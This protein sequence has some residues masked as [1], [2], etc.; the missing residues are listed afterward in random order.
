MTGTEF[1]LQDAVRYASAFTDATG[2]GCTI[3]DS[4]GWIRHPAP[5]EH[6]CRLCRSV[7]GTGIDIRTSSQSHWRRVE[8]AVRFGG[9]YI[10]LCD[11][12]FTHWTSPIV[13]EARVVGALV[14]G[15][16]LTIDDEG[17]FEN[18]LLPSG[19]GDEQRERLR[20]LFGKVPR[21][22][23]ARVTAL[24]RLV[25]ALARTISDATGRALDEAESE[26]ERQS[27][28][29]E[30]IHDLKMQ[31]RDVGLDPEIPTYPLDTERSLLDQIRMGDISRAQETLNELLGH[32]FFASGSEID[33]IRRRTRELVVLL[34]RAV[35]TEGAEPEE[36]FGL[37][38][39]FVDA[40]DQQQDIAGIAYW[41]ARITRRFADLVLYRP[42]VPHGTVM[43][44]AA[45]YVRSHIADPIRIRDV[46]RYVGLSPTYFSRLFTREMGSRFVTYVTRARIYRAREL[47]RT[48]TEPVTLIASDVGI[49]DHSYF[50]KLFRRETG[51]T[52]SAYRAGRFSSR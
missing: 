40:L 37:N 35:L 8:Q 3:L 5:G 20:E 7:A 32:V 47:L 10:Y 50:A 49:P 1:D 31:R 15:P 11:N 43:R 14:A 6:P 23:P 19:V 34:S 4:R 38:Y 52:P 44:K 29:S 28:M 42:N 30:Y 21:L 26:L 36:V 51:V 16:V 45:Q 18:D 25:Y 17:F 48:T 2:I 13:T 46:S 22:P 33:S 12:S 24:S 39:R 27:R 9:R 41:M